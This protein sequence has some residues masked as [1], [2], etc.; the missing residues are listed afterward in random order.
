MQ[1]DELKEAETHEYLMNPVRDKHE[2][3]VRPGGGRMENT[4]DHGW[5]SRTQFAEGNKTFRV[6]L[7]SK[8]DIKKTYSNP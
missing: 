5:L 1:I 4:C 2:S 3:K 8:R 7:E 6:D